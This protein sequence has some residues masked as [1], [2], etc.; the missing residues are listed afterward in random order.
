MGIRLGPDQCGVVT[1]WVAAVKL[2]AV[3]TRGGSDE[4][5][6]GDAGGGVCCGGGARGRCVSG[7]AGVAVGRA[8]AS[9]LAKSLHRG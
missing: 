7:A 8:P 1:G 9:A 6:C 2:G 5:R 4:N 3:M